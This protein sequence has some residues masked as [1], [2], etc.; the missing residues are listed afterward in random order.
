[1]KVVYLID[2]LKV[3]GAER[4]LLELSSKLKYITPVV[5]HLYR[6]DTLRPQFEAAGV[7]VISLNLDGPY[8]FWRAYQLFRSVCA[9]E[10]P[11]AI[12]SALYRSD[13]VARI[14]GR[15]LGIMQIGSWVS[16]SYSESK[17]ATFSYFSRWKYK[18]FYV[19][20][21]LTI[22][23]CTAIISNSESIKQSNS[24]AL[25]VDPAKVKVIYRG[26]EI[27]S[28]LQ[29]PEHYKAGGSVRFLS[30]GRLIKGKGL[31][32]LV[33]AFGALSRNHPDASLTIAGDGPLTDVLMKMI[34]ERKLEDR[35]KLAGYVE[36]VSALYASHHCLVFPSHLEGLSG[37][38]IESML[39][40]L[41][42]LASDIPM[43]RE[44]ITQGKTGYLFPVRNELGI[45]EAMEWFIGHP[46]AAV[47]MSEA[48]YLQALDRFD[49]EHVAQ[50]HEDF[51]KV[52]QERFW[53]S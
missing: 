43:N 21:R 4:S 9:S 22:R 49:I 32:E 13:L 24:L 39:H 36:D 20:N 12:V 10:K 34:A 50:Q 6:G 35:V 53:N 3:G 30:V 28:D 45:L 44:I 17:R 40:H 5:C 7:R 38:L 31:E 51:L 29:K 19:L 46:E 1:M 2:T 23:W 52:C 8:Q 14:V 15:K 41:P 16:D 48:A 11:D 42:I 47:S 18:G 26:R 27:H 37:V 33:A 25:G